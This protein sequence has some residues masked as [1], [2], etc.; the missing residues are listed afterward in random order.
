QFQAFQRWWLNEGSTAIPCYFW[1]DLDY[2]GIAILA[3]LEQCFMNIAAWQPG[4]RA[5]LRYHLRGLCHSGEASGKQRQMDPG[6][7]H[8]AYANNV[9]LPLLRS[10]KMFVDQEVVSMGDLQAD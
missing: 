4:Y 5:M 9:L 2:S 3:A 7:V 1:G 6:G 10:T 8:C